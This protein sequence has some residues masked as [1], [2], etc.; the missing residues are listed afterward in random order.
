MNFGG[1]HWIHNSEQFASVFP[2]VVLV[3]KFHVL[4][5]SSVPGKPEQLV[6]LFEDN[7]KEVTKSVQYLVISRRI[8]FLGTSRKDWLLAHKFEYS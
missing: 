4:E 7:P 1:T 8:Y 2:E 6:T 5:T 3:L